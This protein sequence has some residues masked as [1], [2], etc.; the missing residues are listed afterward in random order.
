MR[1]A[2]LALLLLAGAE[3]SALA[4]SCAELPKDP[5]I[6]R[7]WVRDMAQG[8]IAL[9]E[10]ERIAD[11]DPER[12]IDQRLRVRR[13]LFGRAAGLFA[14]ERRRET[15]RTIE[16]IPFTCEMTWSIGDD[17][18]F[19]LLYPPQRRR[20]SGPRF[21]ISSACDSYALDNARFRTAVV[22]ALMAGSR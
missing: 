22:R 16:D 17:R 11:A 20:G 7:S 10:V 21:R 18:R 5:A 14:V 3:A 15:A 19:V 1:L 9:V 13:I 6:R 2:V 8:A 12:D 4:C